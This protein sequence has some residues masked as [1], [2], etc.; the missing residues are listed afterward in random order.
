MAEISRLCWCLYV[1]P[2][3]PRSLL[4]TSV[5]RWGDGGWLGPLGAELVKGFSPPAASCWAGWLL[6]NTI[7]GQAGGDRRASQWAPGACPSWLEGTG[8][9]AESR[10]PA[11]P[12]AHCIRRGQRAWPRAPGEP[13][14]PHNTRDHRCQGPGWHTT[15]QLLA[16][17]ANRSEKHSP[18]GM[19]SPSWSDWCRLLGFRLS[20]ALRHSAPP[21]STSCVK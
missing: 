7:P 1:G 21:P 6:R 20:E 19:P 3:Y 8:S 4:V 10:A 11:L 15:A 18:E 5:H 14:S 12:T 2:W 9:A 16:L 13:L 17:S